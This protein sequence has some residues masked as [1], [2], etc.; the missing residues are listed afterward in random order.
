MISQL[1][2]GGAIRAA[3]E[4]KGYTQKQLAE[5]SGVNIDTVQNIEQGRAYPSF[6]KA[7]AIAR[8][9]GVKLDTLASPDPL[10]EATRQPYGRPVRREARR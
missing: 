1:E 6:P 2:L 7:L 10:V 3:R 5:V 4:K 9:L 8:A